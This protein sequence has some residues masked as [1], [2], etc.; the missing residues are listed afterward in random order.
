AELGTYALQRCLNCI[1][2]REVGEKS[3]IIPFFHRAE[4]L[5]KYTQRTRHIITARPNLVPTDTITR[6]RSAGNLRLRRRNRKV[7]LSRDS[8]EQC[9]SGILCL[10]DIGFIERVNI[11]NS[12]CRRGRDLPAHELGTDRGRR[13]YTDSDDRESGRTEPFHLAVAV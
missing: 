9:L 4:E 3:K 8:L 10:L 5:C 2:D 13:L 1:V 6:Q 11:E 7:P 12:A